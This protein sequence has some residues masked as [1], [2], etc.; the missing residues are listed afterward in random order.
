M[1]DT[2]LLPALTTPL[3]VRL[4]T[5]K[6]PGAATLWCTSAVTARASLTLCDLDFPPRKSIPSGHHPSA[7]LT[8]SPS[9]PLGSYPAHS[10]ELSLLSSTPHL[11]FDPQQNCSPGQSCCSV[12]VVGAAASFTHSA[13]PLALTDSPASAGP[14]NHPTA[15]V[16]A[17]WEPALKLGGCPSLPSG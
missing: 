9:W 2:S 10:P 3:P 6:P 5:P 17:R 7:S 1:I 14:K 12:A 11:L 8:L 16:T 4:P 15:H 13:V